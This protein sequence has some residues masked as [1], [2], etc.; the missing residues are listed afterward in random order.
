[1]GEPRKPGQRRTCGSDHLRWHDKMGNFSRDLGGGNAELTIV[2][3]AYRVSLA[4]SRRG[5]PVTLRGAK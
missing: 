1:V 4:I 5:K 2:N 3:R